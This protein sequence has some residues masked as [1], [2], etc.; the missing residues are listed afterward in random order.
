MMT[1][2]HDDNDDV[3]RTTTTTWTMTTAHDDSDGYNAVFD[4]FFQKT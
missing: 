2:A 1:T 4:C 3:D